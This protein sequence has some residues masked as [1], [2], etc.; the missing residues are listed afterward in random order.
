MALKQMQAH[1]QNVETLAAGP[2]NEQIEQVLERDPVMIA[3]AQQ[4]AA[5]QGNLASRKSKFGPEHPVRKQIEGRIEELTREREQRKTLIAEQTRQ[6]DLQ[7]ARQQLLV[8]QQRFEELQRLRQ[9]A[10]AKKKDM[11]LARIEFDKIVTVRDERTA[12]LNG[13]REQMEKWRIKLND[14][15]TAK[16]RIKSQAMAPLEMDASRH[17]M[18]WFP[19]GTLLGLLLGVAL[20]FLGEMLNDQLRGPAD[21]TNYLPIPLLGLIPDEAEDDRAGDADLYQVVREAPH[22]LLAEGYRRLRTHLEQGGLKTLLVTGAEPED[23]A[24]AT[25]TNLALAFAAQGKRV[26]LVDG[27]FRQP[28]LTRAFPIQAMVG[29][30]G[31]A[32]FGLSNILLGQCDPMQAIRASGVNGLDLIDTGLLPPNPAEL[33]GGLA[34]QQALAKLQETYDLIVIDSPPVLL[35]SDAKVLARSVAATLLVFSA[36]NTRRGAARRAV[37]EI[38]RVRGH[39]VGCVLFGV[40][41]L[42]G[43]YFRE[44]YK[45][46]ARYMQD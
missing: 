8:M 11:D 6:A 37:E 46:Y 34:M 16:V 30:P 44:Q 10:E 38:Q 21:V 17:W 32:A 15:E 23:G 14:P 7:N 22:S 36:E 26:L 43:G 31:P 20:A 45:S 19:S 28:Y 18:V 1:I 42:K 40:R 41:A 13:I 35:V 9:E 29:Q 4:L 12:V 39:L 33:L 3:L 27:N 25:A 2:I 24:T 5:E